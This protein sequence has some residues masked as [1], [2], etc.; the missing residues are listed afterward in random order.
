MQIGH[1]FSKAIMY[2]RIGVNGF[3]VD[4][5]WFQTVEADYCLRK[6]PL[7]TKNLTHQCITPT[8]QEPMEPGF[9]F[10]AKDCLPSDRVLQKIGKDRF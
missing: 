10:D 3:P 4:K 1:L 5:M 7:D 9:I 2:K 6:T 8:Q